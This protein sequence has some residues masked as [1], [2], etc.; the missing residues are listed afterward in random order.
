MN[1]TVEVKTCELEGPAL[2]WAVA[3]AQGWIRYEE[4]SVELGWYWH[5]D[6]ENAPYGPIIY[7]G[8][9]RPSNNWS[10]CGPLIEKYR[11]EFE[12]VGNDWHG[13]PLNFFTACGFDMPADAASA[14]PTHLIAACR[15][16]VRAKYGKTVSVPAELIK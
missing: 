4:D 3:T 9:W 14:G 8:D 7:L 16:I 12:W 5:T 1:E 11:F 13:E 15:A 6:P 10:Q 2:D